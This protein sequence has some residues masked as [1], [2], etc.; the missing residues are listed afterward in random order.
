MNIKSVIVGTAI[1]AILVGSVWLLYTKGNNKEEVEK[2]E[3]KS[4]LETQ[5]SCK[6]DEKATLEIV[7]AEKKY[8][9]E[10][11]SEN[12][13]VIL[14]NTSGEYMQRVQFSFGEGI[15]EIYNVEPDDEYKIIAYDSETNLNLKIMTVDYVIPSYFPEE[16]TLNTT[17]ENSKLSGVFKNNSEIELYPNQIMIFLKN[18]DG[19]IV[20]KT[21]EYAGCFFEGLVIKPGAEFN[22]E[23][24]IPEGHILLKNKGIMFKYSDLEFRMYE[25]QNF[26]EV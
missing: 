12:Y 11:D 26:I 13:E 15:Y 6:E 10:W 20:Q 25:T 14:K 18:Q 1:G 2:N 17:T 4:N 7:R 21:I 19:K 5:L 22:F 16:V 9:E 3:V 23:F 8:F 24:E